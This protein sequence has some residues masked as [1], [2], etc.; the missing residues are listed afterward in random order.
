MADRNQTPKA[1]ANFE[2]VLE[3]L[4]ELILTG[5]LDENESMESAA[6]FDHVTQLYERFTDRVIA[7]S[8]TEDPQGF[9]A[10]TEGF[11][12]EADETLEEIQERVRARVLHDLQRDASA[13]PLAKGGVFLGLTRDPKETIH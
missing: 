1:L 10:K 3:H 5:A 12:E 6:L 8:A 7:E 4:K 2:G 13:S 11:R 9:T